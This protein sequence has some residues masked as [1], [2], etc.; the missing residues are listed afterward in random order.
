MMTGNSISIKQ[1]FKEYN[2]N[3]REYKDPP[4]WENTKRLSLESYLL[5]IQVIIAIV[6]DSEKVYVINSHSFMD[7]FWYV[8]D[9]IYMFIIV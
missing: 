3:E 4:Y 8:I 1:K 9:F 7:I 2:F 5:Y 6:S